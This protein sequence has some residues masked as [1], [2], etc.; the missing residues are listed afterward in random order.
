MLIFATLDQFTVKWWQLSTKTSE[1]HN[2]LVK[3]IIAFDVQLLYWLYM[4]VLSHTGWLYI[5][6]VHVG[7]TINS[8]EKA[9]LTPGGSEAIVYTTLSGTVGMLAPFSSRE[10]CNCDHMIISHS[11]FFSTAFLQH[12]QMHIREE[13]PV[14]CGRDHLAYRSYY[15]PIKVK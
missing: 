11:L 8:L 7:E 4:I 9:T 1:D 14:L 5:A 2:L 12:F 6:T 13:L 10:V 15:Y 3:I